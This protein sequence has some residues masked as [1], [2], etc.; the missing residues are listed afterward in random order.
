[1]QDIKTMRTNY[2]FQTSKEWESTDRINTLEFRSHYI[3]FLRNSKPKY[4]LGIIDKN[5]SDEY[6]SLNGDWEFK[7]HKCI[8]D[9]KYI[10]EELN[11]KIDVPSC[12]QC[13]GFDYYQYINYTYPYPF[14]PPFVP[15]ENPCFH[16]RRTFSIDEIKNLFMVFEGVDSAFY[17]LINNQYVGYS[18]IAHSKSEFNVTNYVKEGL[19]V[20][21]VVVLKWCA[22]SYL[23]DQDKFRFSGIFRDVYLLNRPDGYIWDYKIET[24]HENDYWFLLVKNLSNVSFFVSFNGETVNVLKQD[25]AKIKID[26]PNLWSNE[27]PYL[28]D[29][30]IFNDVEAIHERIGFRKIEI[31]NKIFTLNGEKIK[32][33]G[34]NRHETNPVNGA[35]VSITDT[36]K[37]LLLIKEL[38]ANAIRTSHYPDIPEFYELCDLLGIYLVD[39]ADVESHGATQ[40]GYSLEKWEAFA[41]NGIYDDAV[42]DR[43]QSLYERDKNRTSVIIWS[44]G[45]ESN[46][47][48]MFYKGADY[49]HSH[50]S[51]PIHYE[52]IFNLVNRSDYYT[53]RIDINSM[54]YPS[55][56]TI[57]EK[58][59]DDEKET[60]PLL[61]CEYT[62]A[63]GNS[64]GDVID[65]W[66]FINK[67]DEIIGAFVWEYCDHAVTVDGKLKY[68][69]D[70]PFH[71]HDNNFCVDGLVSP[72]REFKSSALLIQSVYKDIDKPNY[73]TKLLKI[74]S[75]K[76]ITKQIK[77]DSSTG[78]ITKIENI[79]SEPLEICL[80]RANI[81]NEMF[82]KNDIENTRNAHRIIKQLSN[83][84]F[85]ITFI[86]KE[87]KTIITL[88]EEIE[89]INDVIK[90]VL[91]Y[92]RNPNVYLQRVG[93]R[94]S[95]KGD[96]KCTYFGFGPEES[97]CDK[98]NHTKIGKYSFIVSQN[99]I[100]YLKPQDYGSHYFTSYVDFGD[101]LIS[102][103]KPF[104]FSALRNSEDDLLKYPHD[105]D[106][107]M[108][109]KCFINID[110]ACSGVGSHACGPKLN[111][112][113]LVPIE[114]TNTFYLK[115]KN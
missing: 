31:T 50:D 71:L 57:K 18:Q 87:N 93:F 75:D 9:I 73:E 82:D 97:Y 5:S 12:V 111:E 86:S 99:K 48:K 43:E 2:L 49:I 104:S 80:T 84:S 35:T 74:E 113:Y 51:R 95:I 77:V 47:G 4:F 105:Y 27:N 3:P 114:G 72:L 66:D 36:Y 98:I 39:E 115:I 100:P 8:D 34:V 38:G 54:M 81:D 22:S 106:L 23:E 56:E 64:C 90:I 69:S 44:L 102:A 85:E 14:N 21:D 10:D 11:N 13:R 60:R 94:L 28:Y 40:E 78:N 88:Y 19:N 58:Y 79:L 83:N 109:D 67:H 17:L 15:K 16:Y 107:P 112:K 46:W 68:G 24:K 61:L 59:L 91:S 101:L 52:G 26:N 103:D 29:V 65:Y 89:V 6:L 20:V 45:N 96:R 70:F 63:M 62:H 55:L 92:K 37:D 76:N 41:N 53:N 33:K 7:E 42:F 30:L 32:L 25:E 110:I 108:H 1:M